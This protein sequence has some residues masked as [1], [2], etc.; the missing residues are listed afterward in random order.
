ML[1][2][3]VIQLC[4]QHIGP[5]DLMVESGKCLVMSGPSGSGKS[6]LLRAVADLIPHEG[7]AW[8]GEQQC[9]YTQPEKWRHDIG[10]LPAESQWW[11]DT[12]GEHFT[13]FQPEIFL[14]LGFND[15]VMQW[16]VSRCSTGERQRLA[17]IRLLQGKPQALLLDEPT[18]NVDTQNT[19][20]IEQIILDYQRQNNI[21]VLWVSHQ[22]EQVQRIA[23]RH[24]ALK[25][26]QLVEQA[27]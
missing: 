22:Q 12:V 19:R 13:E 7:E 10:F 24:V 4:V 3:K 11:F 6:L 14:A 5:I 8:L 15:S 16:E 9:S 21:P 18:A 17:L 26:N 2:L 23:D 20:A 27:L 1:D 25:D